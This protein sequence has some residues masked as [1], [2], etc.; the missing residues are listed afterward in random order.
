MTPEQVTI[1]ARLIGAALVGGILGYERTFHSKPGGFRTHILVCTTATL[2]LLLATVATTLDVDAS[3]VIQG[4]MTGMGFLGAGVIFREQLTVH[5]LTSAASLWVTGAIGVMI[6]IG[7]YFAAAIAMAIALL[8]QAGLRLLE[9]WLPSKTASRLKIAYEREN[10]P[11]Q[12]E[13]RNQLEDHGFSVMQTGY[14]ISDDGL[15]LEYRMMIATGDE[16]KFGD[17]ARRLAA[18]PAVKS[19]DISRAGD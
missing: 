8:A 12:A 14:R 13:L 3:R 2:L 11:D 17:L 9:R 19:L 15:R 1:A 5:G 10:A 18:D 16:Q 6:G 7:S 4:L